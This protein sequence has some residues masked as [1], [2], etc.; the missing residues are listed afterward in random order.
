MAAFVLTGV[1]EGQRHYEPLGNLFLFFD[2]EDHP[3][4]DYRRELDLEQGVASVSYLRN[5]VRYSRESFVSYPAQ[6]LT[7]RLT[8][9][10]PGQLSFHTQLAR[11]SEPWN[12]DRF[13]KHKF[14]YQVGFNAY[15]DESRSLSEDTTM[16]RGRCGGSDAVEFASVLKVKV[17][18]GTVR[19]LGNSVIV[20]NAD[21]AVIYVSA[22]TTFR[23]SDP[24][25]WSAAR[26]NNAA[27]MPYDQFKLEHIAD[28]RTLFDRAKLSLPETPDCWM[29]PTDERLRNVKNGQQDD[30][31]ATLYFQYGRYLMIASSRPGS[32]PSTLQGIWNQDMLP[33]WDSKYTININTQMNYWPSESCNLAECHEPLFELLERMREPGA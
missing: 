33:I 8:A 21:E 2:E 14:K 11:G 12:K 26:V 28:Y 3:V 31:L 9:D 13:S 10:K 17:S 29:L 27:E 30:G 1:P 5:G 25:G 19:T 6:T 22:S 4:T 24:L 32:L 23:D 15:V 18:G 7:L 20:E 16:M